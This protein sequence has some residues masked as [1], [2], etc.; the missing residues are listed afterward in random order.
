MPAFATTIVNRPTPAATPTAASTTASSVT[1]HTTVCTSGAPRD[2]QRGRGFLQLL[3]PPT[4]QHDGHAVA[5]QVGGARQADAI[6]H[7]R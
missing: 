7:G 4:G 1:S 5:C 2:A 6:P 3:R